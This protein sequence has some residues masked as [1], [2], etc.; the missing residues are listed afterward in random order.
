MLTNFGQSLDTDAPQPIIGLLRHRHQGSNDG[1]RN[2][3]HAVLDVKKGTHEF[4][5]LFTLDA[6]LTLLDQRPADD[7]DQFIRGGGVDV[8]GRLGHSTRT[9]SPDSPYGRYEWSEGTGDR[10]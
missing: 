8:W 10:R 6:R 9:E 1:P 7:D 5:G 2:L 3:S 4:Q